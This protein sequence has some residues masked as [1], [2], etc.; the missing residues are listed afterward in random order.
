[1]V[2]QY[3]HHINGQW[4]PPSGGEWIDCVNPANGETFA[5]IAKGNVADVDSAVKA[6]MAVVQTDWRSCAQKRID[7][8]NRIADVLES[9]WGALV[10][11]EVSDNGKRIKE[12]RGQFGGLHH[13]YR[14]FATEVDKVQS[15]PLH[16]TVANVENHA[17]YEPYGVVAAITPWNSP[18][19]IAAWKLA[20]ALAAG[21]AV[22][23][24]P[25]EHASVSTLLFANLL[26]T[27]AMPDGL[28]NVV[29][30]YG[31]EVGSA[32]V[33]HP[34]VR[35]VS[36]TGSDAGGVSV[37]SEAA[38]G[39]KPVTLELGGK[40]PQV[41]FADADLDN[42]INGVL[43][44]I[45]LSNGQSCIAGSRLIVEA[46]VLD[47]FVQK[48]IDRVVEFQIGDP[49]SDDTDVGPL[50]NVPQFE[51]VIAMIDTAKREGA[52]CVHGGNKVSPSSNPSGLENGL[53]NGLESG[54]ASG[55]YVEPTIFS[56]VT[57]KMQLW[58]EEVF[59][60]VLAVTSF[61]TEEEAVELANDTEYGLAAGIWTSTESRADR[62]AGR[63]EAGTVY[64]NHYRDVSVGSPIGGFK[65]SGYGR[66][67]GP[68]AVK[69]YMQIKS[70]WHGKAPV[71]DPF[72]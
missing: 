48:L 52:V 63:I 23:L 56:N 47:E 31:T 24:K 59:G 44:G 67:L 17:A 51:K 22:V 64:I 6:A 28:I 21:N 30:G 66:E 54:L 39:L 11:H 37:A 10:E 2:K 60:P 7:V 12:V 68:D 27:A 14:Y 65:R 33:S 40:S 32:L 4:Q 43:S 58:R 55:I 53:E 71:A 41:V 13:W 61:T 19:M 16:N 8:L 25:S 35:K 50:A 29:T 20:P 1:M 62:L 72:K 18:L 57:Q 69:D 34:S 9:E 36:F 42:A 38:V 70:V 49:M 3:G 45:F 26:S 46:A 15:H 5:Q